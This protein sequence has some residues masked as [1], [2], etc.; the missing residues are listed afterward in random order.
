MPTKRPMFTFCERNCSCSTHIW[1]FMG[2][3]KGMYLLRMRIFCGMR[4]LITHISTMF[5]HSYFQTCDHPPYRQKFETLFCPFF[6]K[7]RFLRKLL[8]VPCVLCSH[9][10]KSYLV[11]G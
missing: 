9:P 2:R 1:T 5:H 11:Q 7:R 3:D 4:H 6:F 8:F 10:G